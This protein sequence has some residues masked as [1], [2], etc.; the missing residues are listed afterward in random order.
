[1][2]QLTLNCPNCQSAILAE[3][4]NMAKTLA[5]CR[6]CHTVFDFEPVLRQPVHK[7]QE[8]FMPPGID[9]FATNYELDIEVNWRKTT[10]TLG[11][12]LF[13]ALF[14]NGI[15]FIFVI[16]ALLS[17]SYAMLLGISIHL[18]IGIGFLYYVLSVI[19]NTTYITANQREISVE[20]RPLRLPFYPNRNLAS[21]DIKQVFVE[22]YVAS[23]SNG[24]PNYA[25]AVEAV[26]KD[27]NRIK[28]LKGLKTPE[29]GLYIE[30]EIERFLAIQDEPVAEEW[31][32]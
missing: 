20:H 2:N 18:S 14:W 30:Q 21:R 3:D 26:L 12:F 11:F 32:G 31:K 6:D 8:V 16:A 17:G 27:G 1:M 28:L 23:K 25:F 15:V 24:R 29:Q 4:M 22:K 13:F 5:K 10:K 19:F 9:A 7:K